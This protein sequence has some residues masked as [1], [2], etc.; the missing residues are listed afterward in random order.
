MEKIFLDLL[1]NSD[2]IQCPLNQLLSA[3]GYAKCVDPTC[4][5]MDTALKNFSDKIMQ[6]EMSFMGRTNAG[7]GI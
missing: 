4:I 3:T 5:T 6:K 1:A 7:G 2:I